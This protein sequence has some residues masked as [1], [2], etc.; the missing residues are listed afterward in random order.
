[1]QIVRIGECDCYLI[2]SR[3]QSV[4]CGQELSCQ[5]RILL[6]LCIADV[7]RY[8][9]GRC[10]IRRR[11]TGGF[12]CCPAFLR[13]LAA[14][15]RHGIPFGKCLNGAQIDFGFIHLIV[16]NQRVVFQRI[17]IIICGLLVR[18]SVYACGRTV[19]VEQ[20]IEIVLCFAAY[21]AESLRTGNS[22]VF[23][24]LLAVIILLQRL[25][26]IRCVQL[27]GGNQP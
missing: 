27:R 9:M 4:G 1:M 2:R 11:F 7:F 10:I 18:S 12:K 20:S 8:G 26:E 22:T 25:I 5:C 23:K 3:S 15:F 17:R 6:Y 24:I 19:G 21:C 14:V 16:E 13:V